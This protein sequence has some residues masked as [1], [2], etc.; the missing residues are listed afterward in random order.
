M[1]SIKVHVQ[2]LAL[3]TCKEAPT[4]V[5]R[6]RRW[7]RSRLIIASRQALQGHCSC[8]HGKVG[9]LARSS[10]FSEAA[11]VLPPSFPAICVVVG[12]RS[13]S[14]PCSSIAVEHLQSPGHNPWDVRMAITHASTLGRSMH[15]SPFYWYLGETRAILVRYWCDNLV[16]LGRVFAERKDWKPVEAPCAKDN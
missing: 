3:H 4:W 16:L 2:L 11:Q 9:R 6:Y 8:D 1:K 7:Y 15:E 14:R 13:S 10:G 5:L 12:A